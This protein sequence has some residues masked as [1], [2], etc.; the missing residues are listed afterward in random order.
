[1]MRWFLRAALFALCL[2]ALPVKTPAPL[3]YRPG[4][5]WS[6]EPIGGGKW[7]RQRAKDQL[8]VAQAAF[9]AKDFR[10]AG[11][12]ARRTVR[13]WPLSDYAPQ[14]QFLVARTMEERGKDAEAFKAYQ[15]LLQKYPKIENYD[16]VLQ[17]QFAIANKYLAGK[18]FRFLKVFPYRS[19]EKTAE[20]YDKVVKNGPYSSVAPEAQMNIG[21]AHLQGWTPD[22]DLAVKA[23]ERAADRYHHQKQV[24]AD[25]LFKAAD[26]Y[27]KQAKRAEYDQ[28]ISGKAI[29]TYTDFMTLYPED[30]RVAEAQATIVNLRTEQARGSYTIARYYEKKK[31]W[32]GALIYY[33]ESVLKDPN[34]P[35]AQEARERIEEIKARQVAQAASGN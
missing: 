11:L 6:W 34:S 2:A 8:D 24:A 13:T 31:R 18:Y 33:N 16:E 12:A 3:V 26:T 17:R 10:V 28:S 21:A 32:D 9:E 22:H 14:A 19:P 7:T 25:A 29:A 4:E 20:L 15:E 5:G 35:Y 23:Y 27:L 1:M 30:P